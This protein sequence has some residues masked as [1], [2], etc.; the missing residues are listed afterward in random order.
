MKWFSNQDAEQLNL[1]ILKLNP[2]KILPAT[3]RNLPLNLEQIAH[4][5]CDKLE[6]S[7]TGHYDGNRCGDLSCSTIGGART[8]EVAWSEDKLHIIKEFKQKLIQIID[9]MLVSHTGISPTDNLLHA[10]SFV[11]NGII[12]V[13]DDNWMPVFTKL[14]TYRQESYIPTDGVFFRTR[15]LNYLTDSVITRLTRMLS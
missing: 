15:T 1:P 3:E 13:D 12:K 8:V 14:E 5:Y 7:L 4:P 6:T 2:E 9:P 10:Y 11:S